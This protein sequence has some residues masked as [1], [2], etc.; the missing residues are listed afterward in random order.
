MYHKRNPIKG[1][2]SVTYQEMFDVLSQCGLGT[3]LLSQSGKILSI[4]DSGD[5]LLLG[6]GQLVGTYLA[7]IAPELC[8]DT[9]QSRYAR[10][11]F[12]KYVERCAAPKA[13]DLP[14]RTQLIVFRDA[15]AAVERELLQDVVNQTSEGVIVCDEEN[16]IYMLNDAAVKMDSIVAPEVVGE[17]IEDVYSTHDHSDLLVPTVIREKVPLRNVR[18]FYTTRFGKDVDI[19]S[20]NFPILRNGQVLGGF[21]LMEDWA[22]VDQLHKQI[23]DLQEK[24]T[25]LT[26]GSGKRKAKS[27]LTAKYRF[28]DIIHMSPALH[29]VI[30]HCKQAAKSDSSVMIYGET[31]TG[32]ELFAQSIHSASKRSNGP[33]LAINCAALPEN[34][35]E[36]LLFG[37]EKGAYTGAESRTGLFEQADH[38]TLLL[39][40]I[41]SMNINIQS[42]LLRVLQDGMIRRVGGTSEIHVDVR[43]LSNINIPPHQAIAE[44]KLRQDL[45]YR[46]GVV[47]ISIPPLRERREDIALLAKHFIMQFNRK[48]NKNVSDLSPEALE[49]CRGYAWPGNVRELQ[50]TIE[51]AMNILPADRALIGP[52]DLH[53]SALAPETV[54]WASSPPTEAPA[55]PAAP[56][57][58]AAS[59]NHRVQQAERETICKALR[60]CGGNITRAAALLKMSRQNLQYR[61]KRHQIDVQALMQESYEELLR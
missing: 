54:I 12:G 6:K 7:D 14:P 37:T 16:R 46:L 1:G 47:N 38:G 28:Q 3:L 60:I 9:E 59:L 57:P 55:I 36:G 30:T 23:I 39:D 52:E 34:L 40:E 10:I 2:I 25:A 27:A 48:L 24:L 4:N 15:S 21:S 45:Y 49:L 29:Q 53:L 61:I 35:L 18:Q 8:E 51:H 11:A 20:N 42:K 32:K 50:H 5:Q 31:G 33:F 58:P 26:Q 17:R 13:E 56:K 22:M 41:N 19:M 44:G 43:V